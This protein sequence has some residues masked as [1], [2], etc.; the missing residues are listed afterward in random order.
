MRIFKPLCDR[1]LLPGP[2]GGKYIYA[3][4]GTAD[5]DSN[6]LKDLTGAGG[7]PCITYFISEVITNVGP[8]VLHGDPSPVTVL[9]ILEDIVFY[10]G[11]PMQSMDSTGCVHKAIV[12]ETGA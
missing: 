11:C 5:I 12:A 7:M 3:D 10:T 8:S 4:P 2:E 1:Y 6:S 9:N